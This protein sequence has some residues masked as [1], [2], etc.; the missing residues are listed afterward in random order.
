[1]SLLDLCAYLGLGAAGAATIN[2]LI[3]LMISMRYSPLRQWPHRHVNLFTI[4]Q[5][6]AYATIVLLI[7]HPFVLLFLHSP[8]FQLYDVLF[9]IQSPLQP[10][11]NVLGAVA[12]YLLLAVLITS[13]LRKPIGRPIWRKLHYLVFPA[14]IL[15]LVHSI[16]TDP[17][18]RNGHPDFL[19]GGKVFV[20]ISSLVSVAAIG[21]RLRLRGRGFRPRKAPDKAIQAQARSQS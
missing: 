1:M 10:K 4:H 13:L 12:M 7:A 8:R 9:P 20:E 11:I 19:D 18:L 16:F 17:D 2:L 3:G 14:L 15:L 5:W 21:L 6:T